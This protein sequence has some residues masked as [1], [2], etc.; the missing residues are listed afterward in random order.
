M[1]RY[2]EQLS[3][4]ERCTITQLS[5][6]RQSMRQIAATLDRA[7][8][9]AIQPSGSHKNPSR[10][11]K[12]LKSEI[13]CRRSP[14]F[15][16]DPLP[17]NKR[18]WDCEG[19]KPGGLRNMSEEVGAGPDS[20]SNHTK[21]TGR[22]PSRHWPISSGRKAFFPSKVLATLL[23]RKPTRPPLNRAKFRSEDESRQ[24]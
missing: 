1:G 10:S 17:L 19:R 4:E 24:H 23:D 20:W 2:Y 7:P 5:Q 9:Q 21:G 18:T 12:M 15:G 3:L 13:G 16:A 22:K 14:C 11:R 6:A 8:C